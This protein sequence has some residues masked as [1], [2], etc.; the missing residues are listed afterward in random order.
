MITL[1]LLAALAAETAAPPPRTASAIVC[2]LVGHDAKQAE[3]ATDITMVPGTVLFSGRAE[4]GGIPELLGKLLPSLKESYGLASLEPRVYSRKDFELGAPADI[5]S[6][7]RV[8]VTFVG[9][10]PTL[11]TPEATSNVVANFR[12]R[13]KDGDKTLAEPVV[14]LQPMGRAIVGTRHEGEYVFVVVQ[15]VEPRPARPAPTSPTSTRP[16]PAPPTL[17]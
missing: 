1:V 14:A 16:T 17:P 9:F 4:L 3:K 2:I 7:K 6:G 11:P 12:V 15:S 10:G 5:D 8:E 13:L